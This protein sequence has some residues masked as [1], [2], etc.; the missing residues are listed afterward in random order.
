MRGSNWGGSSCM[1]LLTRGEI[2][3]NTKKGQTGKKGALMGD[4]FLIVLWHYKSDTKLLVGGQWWATQGTILHTK[5]QADEQLVRGW[6]L[7][8]LVSKTRGLTRRYKRLPVY[9]LARVIM[10]TCR[11]CLQGAIVLAQADGNIDTGDQNFSIFIDGCTKKHRYQLKNNQKQ[12]IHLLL[13]A[14]M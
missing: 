3:T 8:Y 7:I 10:S 14:M 4:A 13:M 2:C 6:A 5:W 9:D 11:S 1:S 12:T